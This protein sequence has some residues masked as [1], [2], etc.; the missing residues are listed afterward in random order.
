MRELPMMEQ[1]K[2][3]SLEMVLAI[4]FHD[5]TELI[6]RVE[7]VQ[8]G[9]KSIYSAMLAC[10]GTLPAAWH[11]HLSQSDGLQEFPRQ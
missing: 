10:R 3:F 6:R 7:V 4:I 5:I 1:V 8:R 2:D 11:C 9:G